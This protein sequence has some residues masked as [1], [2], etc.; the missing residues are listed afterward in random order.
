MNILVDI[1]HAAHFHLFK[2]AIAHWK[3]RGDRVVISIRQRDIIAALVEAAGWDYHVT[4]VAGVGRFG[5]FRELIEHDWKVLKLV[6]RY[7]ID[8]MLG[9]SVS[10]A[11]VSRITKARSIVFNED[12]ADYVRLFALLAYP[13]ADRI[14][15][16]D[17]LRDKRNRRYVD[18]RSYH[19]LA[20]LHPSHFAP[21]PG[22]L[23]SL[24]VRAG[25]P[26]FILRLVALKA[27]H[28]AGHAGLSDAAKRRLVGELSR[29]GRVFVSVEG[30]LPDYLTPYQLPI[31]P[32]Q[33]HHAMALATL[34]VSDSQT[35]TMEAAVLGT[36]SIRCNTFVKRCS[37][38]EELEHRYQLTRGFLPSDEQAMFACIQ[39]WISTPDLK[40]E[41]ERRRRRMLSEKTNL[42]A[43]MI[44]YVDQFEKKLA[45]AARD[46][47]REAALQ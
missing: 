19:E 26:F 47:G 7:K 30:K 9:T 41:W 6:R 18:H 39:Q 15:V 17:V 3:A 44:D 45:V 40:A 32:H 33:I 31:P 12:D 38:I 35:M 25:E 1:G 27:H 11:H 34:L 46:D 22:I 20:Y 10:I 23:Q 21:D 43:W 14:V 8:V 13:F 4:S 28:D 36:P 5:L 2:N 24:G 29:H 16:P 42:A 37:V